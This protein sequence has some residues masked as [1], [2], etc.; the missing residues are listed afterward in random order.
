MLYI[1]AAQALGYLNRGNKIFD[2]FF[3][4]KEPGKGSA[5][6]LLLP[7]AGPRDTPAPAPAR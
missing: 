7:I 4:T 1:A 5:F 6:Y 3:T 2:P